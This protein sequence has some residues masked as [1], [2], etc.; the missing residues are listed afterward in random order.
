MTPIGTLFMVALVAV[1]QMLV[2]PSVH[3]EVGHGGG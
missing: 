3:H 2:T 1:A